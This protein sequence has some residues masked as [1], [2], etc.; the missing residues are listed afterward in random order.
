MKSQPTVSDTV[1]LVATHLSNGSDFGTREQMLR[2]LLDIVGPVDVSNDLATLGALGP[3]LEQLQ[4]GDVG[5]RTLAAHVLGA[6]AANNALFGGQVAQAGGV[7]LLLARLKADEPEP[8]AKALYALSALAR[9]AGPARDAF[10]NARGAHTLRAILTT[11]TDPPLLRRKALVLLTDL[12]AT[13]QADDVLGGELQA[14]A[15]AVVSLLRGGGESEAH[16]HS[17]DEDDA[18]EKAL[19]AM[20]QLLISQPSLSVDALEAAGAPPAVASMR[21]RLQARPASEEDGDSREYVQ[22]LLSLLDEV[23]Q[24]SEGQPAVR[25]PSGEL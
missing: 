7:E 25:D 14:V 11:P 8:R 16:T 20:R 22:E 23:E 9:A 13:H 19:R 5:V 17:A 18:A 3:L 10:L 24:L 21:K 12:L 1:K 15:Q 4:A 2:V 6:A